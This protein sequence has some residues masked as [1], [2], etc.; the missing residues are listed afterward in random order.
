[1]T[2]RND[3]RLRRRK[4]TF[5]LLAGYFNFVTTL[6]ICVAAIVVLRRR[7]K[8]RHLQMGGNSAESEPEASGIAK[9]AADAFRQAVSSINPNEVDTETAA[10]RALRDLNVPL[11]MAQ[12]L[13]VCSEFTANPLAHRLFLQMD[14]AG[15]VDMVKEMIGNAYSR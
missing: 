2:T 6:L 4:A 8:R 13:K 7:D 14:N 1:M 9:A 11:T 15:R 10:V 5:V 12:L 3:D